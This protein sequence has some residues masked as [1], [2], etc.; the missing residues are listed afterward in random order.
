[1]KLRYNDY[2]LIYSCIW[3]QSF[4]GFIPF[5]ELVTSDGKPFE[6]EMELILQFLQ[7]LLDFLELGLPI[8]CTKK[9]QQYLTELPES[10]KY[11]L[12][13]GISINF[14]LMNYTFLLQKR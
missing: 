7:C 13:M 2:S 4:T 14:I 1:M 6:T 8:L 3:D 11:G 5:N 12:Q 9:K 10:F